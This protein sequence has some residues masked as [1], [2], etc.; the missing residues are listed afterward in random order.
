MN[1][2]VA[3]GQLF[4]NFLKDVLVSGWTTAAI[5]LRRGEPVRPGFVRMFYGELS[6]TAA[7]L[8]GAL[9]TLTP[10][11][12]TVDI[13]LQRREFLLHLLDAERAELT[14]ASIRR[15]FLLP[16]RILFEGAA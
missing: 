3:V 7:N 1:K 11:T 12:T 16:V 10:G 6:D 2:P 5:I 13:D 8:L 9:I 4:F 14:L 15:D